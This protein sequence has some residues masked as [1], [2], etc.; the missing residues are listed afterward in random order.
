[1]LQRGYAD[2]PQTIYFLV[3]LA[4]DPILSSPLFSLQPPTPK[5]ASILYNYPY[6]EKKKK[7]TTQ[8][9]VSNKE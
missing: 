8:Y 4:H 1:M 5:R 7:K 2:M 3:N 6:L 9:F